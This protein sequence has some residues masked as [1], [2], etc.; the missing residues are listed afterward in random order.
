MM[1]KNESRKQTGINLP[2]V[3][4]EIKKLLARTSSMAFLLDMV[5]HEAR[6]S[7]TEKS[8]ML[9]APL[10]GKGIF[11]WLAGEGMILRDA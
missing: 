2:T 5:S 9:F 1:L 10:R 4:G 3:E 11:F 8:N 6:T 7:T